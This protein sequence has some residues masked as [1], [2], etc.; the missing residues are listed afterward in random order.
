MD[1]YVSMPSLSMILT[2][3]D[4]EVLVFNEESIHDDVI[5]WKKNCTLLA[6]CVGNS[7]VRCEFLAQSPVMRS[8]D[9]FF[10]MR[11]NKQLSKQ[12]W[13]SWFDMLSCPLWRHNNV[14][15]RTQ[16]ATA[17]KSEAMELALVS[18][19]AIFWFQ[20]IV[21]PCLVRLSAPMIL[22]I[23]I[24]MGVD[25]LAVQITFQTQA[26]DYPTCVG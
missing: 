9:V 19:L 21:A 7:P 5:K 13:G 4:K 1:H 3:Q 24:I 12:L 17:T 20:H 10:D 25:G 15:T 22:T 16:G 6:I 18:W 11:P 26:T 23:V 2:M 14:T 8:F